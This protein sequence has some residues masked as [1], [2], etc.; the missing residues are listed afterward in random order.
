M[1][2]SNKEKTEKLCNIKSG[3]PTHV[4]DMSCA[5]E[6]LRVGRGVWGLPPKKI[7]IFN[8][9]FSTSILLLLFETILIYQICYLFVHNNT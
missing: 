8:V 5:A 3:R 2:L 9:I 6:P 1:I 7:F 4:E